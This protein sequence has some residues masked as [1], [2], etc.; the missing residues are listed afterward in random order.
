MEKKTARGKKY[1]LAVLIVLFLSAALSGCVSGRP[2]PGRPAAGLASPEAALRDTA[3]TAPSPGTLKAI[4]AIQVV[5]PAGAYPLKLAV[6]LR[7]PAMMRVEAIPVLG[8]P[9]FYLVIHEGRLKALLPDKNEFYTGR[10]TR[11]NIAMF[12]P[13]RID[14]ESMVSLLMGVPPPAGG[15]DP[16]REGSMEKDFYR[17]DI[18]D[19]E[20]LLQSIRVHRADGTLA[21]V[22]IHDGAGKALYRVRYED[23]LPSGGFVT[24]RKITIVSE[25][26]K[27]T[28][29]IRYTEIEWTFEE[30]DSPFEL[31]VPPGVKEGA[32]P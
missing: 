12:L 5:T 14:V 32:F 29:T 30:D 21:G 10:A 25:E 13:L 26:D 17:I 23:P 16:R 8:P 7:R 2:D 3:G 4:A 27:T 18:R 28:L 15:K 9:N 1:G 19:G 11:E 31:K 22:D 6:M 20:S 24:P